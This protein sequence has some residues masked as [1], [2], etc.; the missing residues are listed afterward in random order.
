MI[1]VRVRDDAPVS[2]SAHNQVDETDLGGAGGVAVIG[3]A[4]VDFGQ[5]GAGSVVALDGWR[6]LGSVE[7]GTLR[8][9]GT[10][11]EVT[12]SG[13][14]YTG[15]AGGVTVFTLEVQADGQYTFTLLDSIDHADRNDPNDVI[16]LEFDVSVVDFDG[17]SANGVI[18]ID[19]YDDGPRIISV[20]PAAAF[21]APPLAAAASISSTADIDESNLEL[22]AQSVDGQFVVDFGNDGPGTILPNGEF[23]PSGS[24]LNGALTSGGQAV[25]VTFSG[26]TYT[27]ALA[28]GSVIFTLEILDI[29]QGT[30]T[31]TLFAPLDHA[32]GSKENDEIVLRFGV[33]ATDDDGDFVD[34]FITRTIADDAPVAENDDVSVGESQTVTG[35]VTDNDDAGSDNH[36][37]I[38]SVN[39]TDIPASGLTING[40]YGVL[41]INRD[42]SYS[43]TANSNNPNGVDTFTYV[44][45][46]FDGDTDTAELSFT[47]SPLNDVPVIT[48]IVN[49]ATDDSDLAPTDSDSGSI[50]ATFGS[51]GAGTYEVNDTFSSA[52]N[53]AGNALTSNGVAVSVA[54][55]GNDYVGTAGGAEVFRL[56]LNEMTGEY[57]FT[58]SRPLDHS[59]TNADNEAITLRFGVDVSDGDG[60]T[61]AG[62]TASGT[63]VVTVRDDAPVAI[64]DNGGNVESGDSVSGNV[65]GNDNAGED[66]PG[67]VVAVNG[68]SIPVSGLT[69]N[70]TYGVLV[71]DRDGSYTYTANDNTVGGVDTFTYTLRDFDGDTDT[72]KLSFAVGADD[73]PQLIAPALEVVDETNLAGGNEVRTGTIDVDFGSDGPGTIAGNG[74]F[75]F[76]G[77]A[78]NDA[79]THNG[80]PVAV[81]LSG[82]TYTGTAADGTDVFTL[83][84]R[85]D[86]SYTF[87]LLDTL[88][89]ADPNDPNDIIRLRFGVVATDADGDTG[90]TTILVDVKDDAPSIG[91]SQG[92]VDEINLDNGVLTASD[93]LET[94]F[95]ADVGS[96]AP[97]GNF[98]VSA[99]GNPLTLTSGGNAVAIT[100]T[101]NGY[102]GKLAS[103]AT[104]FT[105]SIDATTGQWT[106]TQSLPLD[107]PDAGDANDIIRFAF[108][109]DVTSVDGDSDTGTIVVRVADDG[110]VAVGDVNGAE[111]GQLI[112]GDVIA[113]D[114][115]STDG[116]HVINQ[117]TFN[118]T[119]FTIPA[120]G[121]TVVGDFGTLTIQQDGSYTYQA[122][123]NDPDGMDTFT[124]RIRDFDGDTDT[125]NLVI[126]VSPDGQPVAVDDAIAVDETNL[127]PGPMVFND[128]IEID[129]GLD[130]QGGVSPNGSFQPGGSLLGGNLTSGGQAITVEQ[131]ATGYVGTAGGRDIFTI[132]FQ[133]NGEYTFTLLDHIDH[134]DA[135]DPNDAITLRFGVTVSD[136]DGDTTDVNVTVTVHDDAPVAID[137]NGGNVAESATVTGN[138]TDNDELGEDTPNTVISVNG[139]TIPASGL[140][141]NGTYGVLTI[142]RD[143]SY[144]YTAN[145]DNPQGVDRFTYV[146]RDFDG[147][148]DTAEL[149]FT[150]SPLN[151]VPVIT[152][153]VNLATDDSDL[154]P[155]DS[156]SG[157]ITATFGSDGEGTYEVNDT[158]SSA[159]NLAGNA[160]TSNGVAVN[161]TVI[162]NDYVGTAGGAEV[163]RLTLSETTGEYTFT[164]SRPLDHSDTNANNEAITLR[165]GVD[166]SDGDS[167]TS[168]G[169]TASGTI[170]VTVRDDAPV[171]V[172][173]GRVAVESET[174]TGN[175][176]NNDDAGADV[177]GTVISVNGTN[178]PA[179][180][181]TIAGNYG[182]LTIQRDGS[183]SY[184][185]NADNPDGADTFTYALRDRDGDVDLAVLSVV[186]SPDNDVPVITNIVNLTTDDSDL[187]PTDSDSGSIT[188]TFGSDGEGT[189][190][191][192]DTFSSAGNL[193]GNALTSNG[194]AVNVTVI[195][196]DYVGT[197]GGAEVFRLTLSETTGEYTFTQSRPL[198]H[199]DTN[200]NNEAITLRFGVDVSDGD[201][202]TSAGDT[203]S[204]TIV[205]TVR[206]DAPV[207]VD[208]NGGNLEEG[209]STSG[210]VITNDDAGEDAPGTIVAVN[211]TSIPAAGLTVNG[212]YGV[213]V[214]DRD[215]SYTYTA[216]N[217]STGGVDR[218]TYTLRDF[219][220]DTD[221]ADLSFTVTADDDPIVGGPAPL[222]VDETDLNPTDSDSD[223]IDVDFGNDAPGAFTA[224]GAGTFT[225]DGNAGSRLTSDGQRVNVSVD[226]NDY[227]GR[228]GGQEVF[229]LE[230]N[231]TTGQYEFILLGVLD[232]AD[233]SDPND[234]ITLN[235]GVTVSDND[236][237][238]VATSIAVRVLDDG[239]VANND[240]AGGAGRTFTGNVLTNDVY[241]EDTPNT[242]TSIRYQGVDYGLPAN[243][244]DIT[245]N[246]STGVLTINNTGA[247]TFVQHETVQTFG[248]D[249]A[250][251]TI[252]TSR[253]GGTISFTYTLQ[254]EDG[255][256]DTANLNVT[257]QPYTDIE[258]IP[259]CPLVL[260]LDGDGIELVTTEN[261]VLFDM[262][263]DGH[264]EQTAWVAAD[265]GLLAIDLNGDG[266]IN[267]H[268]ELFGTMTT[269]GFT[270]LG[271]YDSNADGV[272]DANDD[273]F[274]QML[275]WQDVNQDGYSDADELF[276]LNDLGIVSIDLNAQDSTDVVNGSPIILTSTFNYADGSEGQIG[277]ALFNFDQL[278]VL[279]ASH[280]AD[281]FIFDAANDDTVLIRGFDTEDGDALDLSALI[282]GYDPLSDAINDFVH[283]TERDGDTIVSVNTGDAFHA[284]AVLENVTN[285]NLDD[286]LKDNTSIAA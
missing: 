11:V 171:A 21:A 25:D 152:N 145:S 182:V 79:L 38:V 243:G 199:S 151:D 233:T 196:N 239:P 208:D 279:Y 187:N 264:L 250:G 50:T 63:I 256:I 162:G 103:G 36:G 235:F 114:D 276:G 255:D 210:N 18:T 62:D 73:V 262:G 286:I 72:A 207:A 64:D 132:T 43:Y 118:G 69:V 249:D 116:G 184:T 4:L 99:G 139:T 263:P 129:F 144:S 110:P 89:H 270:I 223:T 135:S 155:T 122:N 140:T 58:Q 200:A 245:I 252:I 192:N 201:S 107:H 60:D 42:G 97:N 275:V 126:R 120:G 26:N 46:D 146:L 180:G 177:A 61:S 39:G 9:E 179:A 53:R 27:G 7:T 203:A 149:S 123:N 90:T 147:D 101:A 31:F 17:D 82:N 23:Q 253:P 186:V 76:S 272:I 130:G 232:H 285:V 240:S 206:D 67:S 178:I 29:A 283:T 227:V 117:I 28:D 75:D 112:T 153:I 66:A 133:D 24:L 169:D 83:V 181:L 160:L 51:D 254:D 237:D 44:L 2:I 143:G 19:V 136:S 105:L 65:T 121:R 78:A 108:D 170:V 92:G 228:A 102:E 238:S 241:S 87:T 205:V 172:D 282:E 95:G 277:D 81:T 111:E 194:V 137:D 134:A 221:T 226:G 88:D 246:S 209:G 35:N 55:V 174:I 119:N 244:N 213:L 278:D 74:A 57:T 261:G 70:G 247:Y 164:Q 168:A 3:N 222:V 218:F 154:N 183:Y 231:R 59:D 30:H 165:F 271:Q 188:A 257:T 166:V 195:G 281:T 176:T 104:V 159:G 191:V 41:T 86:G 93:T 189:Y 52:G 225:Y 273:A 224:T 197:A 14:T 85:N 98:S 128:R 236:G 91:D 175:V 49:L 142:A 131:T 34:G 80:S 215:G 84:V 109:V 6:A 40:T 193:A 260:D 125:A 127:T 71:I 54:V 141:I 204:G 77:S 173:D 8:H 274:D 251:W 115:L 280:D 33:R 266:I 37:T 202:D 259:G 185:A 158:F 10:P 150:V 190:E 212:T 48:N 242:M 217:N 124:Y 161:V 13:N 100:Q 68:T 220:G 157:S 56:S 20:D 22:G 284:V 219:D 16:N 106:Y 198:D 96:V 248:N 267:D 234:A 258:T 163:F 15:T 32:D 148:T 94:N 265:D 230:L 113:N 216:N 138:V 45:R 269:D 214:I 167:D 5:D 211:G 47:V 12:L 268:S 1:V 156:D 229:R